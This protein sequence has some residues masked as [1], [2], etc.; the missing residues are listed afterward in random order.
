MKNMQNRQWIK[1][2]MA[3]ALAGSMT[4][5][6]TA[7]SGGSKD[8]SAG[9]GGDDT[10][11]YFK[12]TFVETLPDTAGDTMSGS[13]L[14]KNDT[15]Y[16]GSYTDN[17]YNDYA[18]FSYNLLSGE[19][20]ELWR[21]NSEGGNSQWVNYFD[22]SDDGNL[23]MVLQ[24][25]WVDTSSVTEDYSN[26]TLDDVLAY[27]TENWGY[28]TQ[29]DAQKDWD[30]YYASTYMG[31]DGS[32]DYSKFLYNMEGEW[33]Y[34]NAVEAYDANGS[35]LF[36]TELTDLIGDEG[37]CSGLKVD[38]D[39]NL[40]VSMES[41]SD[42]GGGYSILVFD[43][44]G[45]TKGTIG[46]DNW[47]SGLVVL[48]DGRVGACAYG[49]N[50]QGITML[51]LD[52]MTTGEWIDTGSDVRAVK[53][54]NE[55]ILSDGSSLYLYNI[56][57]GS[58]EKYLTWVD[59]N[60]L[61]SSV[62]SVGVL[63]DGRLA[64][65]TS[66]WS[67]RTNKSEVEAA[68]IEEVDKSEIPETT[69]LNVACLWLDSTLEERVIEFNKKSSDTK[70]SIKSY[71]DDSMEYDD[72]VN[73]FTTAV[74]SAKNIDIVIFDNYSQMLNYAS[75][76]LLTDLYALM[77]N[78]ADVKKEDFLP[79]VLNNCEYDGKLVTLPQNFSVNTVVGKT[80]D[81][82]D[83][84]GWTL[85]DMKA[86]LASKE[87]GTQLFYGMTRSSA[88]NLCLSLGYNEFI[89]SADSTCSFDNEDFVDV[90]EFAA[91][92]PEEFEY[93]EDV[94]ET[95]LMNTGK[96]LL[97]QY[98]L[99]DF[100]QIQMYREIFG[101]DLTYIGYPT[102]EGN[103]AMLNFS[104]MMGITED[105]SDKAA[106][107]DFMRQFYIAKSDDEMQNTW[108]FPVR[109]DDFDKFCKIAMEKDDQG[110]WGWGNFEVE[111]KPATQKDVD[112]VKDLINNTTAVNGAISN[113]ILSIIEEDAAAYFAGQKS[114]EEVASTIQG[115]VQ[116]YLSE[117][118]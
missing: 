74:A 23:Y 39:G 48:A 104:E 9:K 112:A 59:C 79:G 70:I 38:K 113:E 49:D 57:D 6:L 72:M 30:E 87:D 1:R 19:S 67:S 82:G 10:Q 42:N 27:M 110:S 34:T 11:H 95:V 78:D 14:I 56:K 43:K 8:A 108:S 21:S 55:L 32:I 65:L 66:S 61:S 106:A 36:T 7:C 93:E 77:E 4:M 28:E 94:D 45:K 12:T 25:S 35:Q 37:Y 26:A 68:L 52:N 73:N 47:V 31:E 53:N 111:L 90:L 115:R 69:Q 76:G 81:V 24:S 118:K 40:L 15:L 60:I 46:M 16:Y 29:E 84:P 80:S 88:L 33:K 117:T 54:E 22:V 5:G 85:D 86:L 116:I 97:S 96:V 13:S 114:A 98:Y 18:V 2:S 63:S 100:D 71:Y 89:N 102:S 64:V 83:T 75:K 91:M 62:S 41:W 105:C 107:W 3:I 44:E 20:K 109:T 17:N 58:K 51:D 101:G 92:F 99:S 103:G 50:G